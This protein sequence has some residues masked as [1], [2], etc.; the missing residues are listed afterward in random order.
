MSLK[1][2]NLDAKARTL[3]IVLELEPTPRPS[4]SGKTMI[5]ATTSGNTPT[6]AEIDGKVIVVGANA[7]FK[8]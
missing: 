4:A 7:Y 2:A 8:P 1:S 6:T 3:T 5:V